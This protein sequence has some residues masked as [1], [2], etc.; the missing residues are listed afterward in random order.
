MGG[1]RIHSSPAARELKPLKPLLKWAGGKR[2]LRPQVADMFSAHHNKRLVEPFCGALG[3]TLGLRPRKALL[4]DVNPHA[5]NFHRQVQAGLKIRLRMNNDRELYLSHREQFN[6]LILAGRANTKKAASLFYFLNRTGY[7]GLCRFNQKG[8]YNVPFGRYNTINYRRDFTDYQDVFG[9]WE[10]TCG[11][12]QSIRLKPTDFIY[13]DPPYDVEFRQYSAGGFPWKDQERLAHWLAKHEGP[14]V[15]SN[16]ATD[17]IL[18]LYN[19]LGFDIE[20]LPGPRAISRTGDRTPAQEM[21]A[22]K[23]L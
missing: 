13:A 1:K 11:D 16:Q 18:K 5:I 10:I 2:W 14:V 8:L 7:N 23:G 17:A 21:L 3:I 4:N 20:T 15:A 12:F 6:A 22:V 19:G 9:D